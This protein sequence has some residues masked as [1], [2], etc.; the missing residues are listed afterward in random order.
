MVDGKS[1][2]LT[3]YDVPDTCDMVAV[4]DIIGPR[5]ICSNYTQLSNS[6]LLSRYGFIDSGCQSDSVSLSAQLFDNIDP[7]RQEFW[8]NKGFQL[9]EKLKTFNERNF[10]EME[11]ILQREACPPKGAPFA[12]WS[13]AVGLCGWVRFPLKVFTTI[14]LLTAEEWEKFIGY[15]KLTEKAVFMMPFMFFFEVRGDLVDSDMKSYS[16][17]LDLMDNALLAK[18]ATYGQFEDFSAFQEEITRMRTESEA[19]VPIPSL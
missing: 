2:D 16:N 19:A 17:W 6:R 13:T 12:Q 9:I 10:Q 18:Q 11:G 8:E 3:I 14:L 4:K 1:L 7:D 15:K 5:Q